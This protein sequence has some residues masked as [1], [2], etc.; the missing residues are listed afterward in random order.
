MHM[1]K[2]SELWFGRWRSKGIAPAT[3]SDWDGMDGA[4]TPLAAGGKRELEEALLHIIQRHHHQSLRQRQQ[5]GTVRRCVRV[6]SYK[7]PWLPFDYA[8]SHFSRTHAQ[9]EPRRMPWEARCG[10]PISSS[11]RSTA[12]CRSSSST[13]SASSM[14]PARCSP[15]S[16][17]TGSRLTSGWLPPTKST[18]SWRCHATPVPS[19]CQF[20]RSIIK[21]PNWNL[22]PRASMLLACTFRFG[23]IFP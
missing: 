15:L 2:S 19:N 18:Q 21:W 17:A 3:G 9:R 7:Y 1:Q 6:P 13:R 16:R 23:F 4:K 14:R 20:H 22:R 11:T 5:T 8:T 10:C 12:A